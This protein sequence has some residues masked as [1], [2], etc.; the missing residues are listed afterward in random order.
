MQMPW[1][2]K[3]SLPKPYEIF[4]WDELSDQDKQ[5]I[6]NRKKEADWYPDEVSPLFNIPEFEKINSIGLRLHGQVVGWLITHRSNANVIEYSSLFVSPELQGL[7]R[8]IHLIIE[9]ARRQYDSGVERAIF[10]VKVNNSAGLGFVQ[11]RMGE[12]IINQTSRWF[13]EKTLR[14]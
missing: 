4:P 1:V 3:F 5:Y 14:A 6:V 12:A 8:G 13:C 9:A 7:G 10:Q 11:K 2:E